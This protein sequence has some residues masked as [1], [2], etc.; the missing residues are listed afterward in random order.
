MER[1]CALCLL[2]LLAPACD[3]GE[4]SDSGQ[5][6]GF[7]VSSSEPVQGA[8]DVAATASPEVFRSSVADT[9]ACRETQWVLAATDESG[10]YAFD[11]DFELAFSEEGTSV[12]LQHQDP[13]LRGFWYVAMVRETESP[14]SDTSGDPIVPFGVE[15]Y[16]P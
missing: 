15:F 11:V 5:L 7:Y 1:C 4:N 2:S 16:V 12:Q 6:T 10:E 8:T 9:D 3:S 13:F 14:C